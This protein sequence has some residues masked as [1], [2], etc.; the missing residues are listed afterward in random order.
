M[1][2]GY[3]T[4]SQIHFL[5]KMSLACETVNSYKLL[6]PKKK[7]SRVTIVSSTQHMYS[8]DSDCNSS[9]MVEHGHLNLQRPVYC[10]VPGFH[11]VLV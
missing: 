7:S 5:R 8:A 3:S 10:A 2:V 1:S 9:A 4:A 11:C 6:I